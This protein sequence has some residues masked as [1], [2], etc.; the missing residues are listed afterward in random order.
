M[1]FPTQ[2]TA[3][4][5][6]LAAGHIVSFSFPS[7]EGEPELE[8]NRPALILSVDRSGDA[9]VATVAHGTSRRTDANKGFE[10][11]VRRRSDLGVAGLRRRTRF[12]G[13]RTTTVALTSARFVTGRA[14]TAVLGCLP[15]HL[16]ARLE[17]VASRCGTWKPEGRKPARRTYLGRR[18]GRPDGG[19]ASTSMQATD[20][21]LFS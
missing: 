8:K 16:H 13:A 1:T 14:D 12:V 7:A 4:R 18:R 17:Q 21:F 3:W 2:T 11:H 10:L 19:G 15:D 5:D 9:P 6:T 20:G